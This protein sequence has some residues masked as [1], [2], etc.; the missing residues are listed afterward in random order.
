M[1]E[2]TSD[3]GDGRKRINGRPSRGMTGGGS[4]SNWGLGTGDFHREKVRKGEPRKDP[5]TGMIQVQRPS[6]RRGA[7]KRLWG[8]GTG[9]SAHARF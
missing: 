9:R 4:A 3:R 6:G 2:I 5:G 8:S 7:E 1:G